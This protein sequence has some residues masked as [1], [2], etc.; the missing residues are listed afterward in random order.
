ME[1]IDKSNIDKLRALDNEHIIRI[2]DEFVK[3]CKPEKVTVI[4]DA[5]E[6][7]EYCRQT[8][9]EIGEEAELK[10][11]GHSIHYDGFYTMSNHDQARDKENTRVLIPKGG[12]ASPWINTIDREEG[13]NEILEIMDGCMEGKECLVRFF[14]L[15]PKNSRFS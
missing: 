9:I 1:R 12:Y 14:C 2:V 8:V 11:Q 6:D 5:I 10:T 4:T 7:I 15:G 3:L 13:L